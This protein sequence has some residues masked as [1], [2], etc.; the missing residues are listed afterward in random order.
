MKRL[1]YHRQ[2]KNI[3]LS[4]FMGGILILLL[5]I[6]FY[7]VFYQEKGLTDVLIAEHIK[8]LSE[9]FKKIDDVCGIIDFDHDKNYIDFLNV[10]SFSGS[11]V[12]SMNLK[13]PEKWQGP[14]LPENLTMQEQPYM[15]VK[16]KKGFFIVPGEGVKLANGKIIG[17]DMVFT[18]DTDIA[19]LMF[20][21]NALLFNDQPLAAPVLLKKH[22]EQQII[23]QMLEMDEEV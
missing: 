7:N 5:G 9:I 13:H 3:I 19:K 15:I 23:T 1:F 14:Y 8:K 12:G 22:P 20:D 4:V 11:E 21:T 10:K 18:H 16:T 2:S 17:K 6:S